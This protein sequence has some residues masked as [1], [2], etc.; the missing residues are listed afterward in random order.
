MIHNFKVGQNVI[1]SQFTSVGGTFPLPILGASL[2]QTR[3][4]PQ[5][6][7]SNKQ[8]LLFNS[9][10]TSH[11]LMLKDGYSPLSVQCPLASH[12]TGKTAAVINLDIPFA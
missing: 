5:A 3:R 11:T 8:R 7:I 6:K 1:L 10:T 2:E 4:A 9:C 12:S